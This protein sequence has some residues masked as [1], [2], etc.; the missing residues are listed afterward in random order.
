MGN[1]RSERRK[2]KRRKLAAQ[3]GGGFAEKRSRERKLFFLLRP[4]P[5]STSTSTT[6]ATCGGSGADVTEDAS[7]AR[8][9]RETEM[10]EEGEKKKKKEI[11][12]FFFFFSFLT[13]LARSNEERIRR[14]KIEKKKS[15]QKKK[16]NLNPSESVI[17]GDSSTLARLPSTHRPESGWSQHRSAGKEEQRTKKVAVALSRGGGGGGERQKRRRN[18]EAANSFALCYCSGAEVINVDDHGGASAE[19]DGGEQRELGIWPGGSSSHPSS[20]ALFRPIPLPPTTKKQRKK[21]LPLS[22]FLLPSPSFSSYSLSS[23]RILVPSVRGS[24]VFVVRSCLL[25]GNDG[26]E[27]K[28]SGK[29]S[30]FFLFSFLYI[31]SSPLPSPFSFRAQS[32]TP[33]A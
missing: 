22:S 8:A 6:N 33:P 24:I 2:R 9:C 11:V 20:L 1:L 31:S 3:R 21:T 5:P 30:L 14:R 28:K 4:L 10:V 18:S 27:L 26:K 32:G 25:A 17:L 23:P 15:F 12:S 7:H 29:K 16:A 13:A 19:A